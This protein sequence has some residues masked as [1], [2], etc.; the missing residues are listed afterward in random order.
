MRIL[1]QYSSHVLLNLV[2]LGIKSD[3]DIYQ[4]LI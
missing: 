3:S 4:L 2:F 1:T